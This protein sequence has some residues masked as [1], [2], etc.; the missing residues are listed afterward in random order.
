[1]PFQKLQGPYKT[2]DFLLHSG[3]PETSNKDVSGSVEAGGLEML[4][5]GSKRWDSRESISK[6]SEP[7]SANFER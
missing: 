7:C 6:F 2:R 3:S 5:G 4:G 1:M